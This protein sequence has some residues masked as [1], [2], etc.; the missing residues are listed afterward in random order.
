MSLLIKLN[1]FL[2]FFLII[3]LSFAFF[4]RAKTAVGGGE[5][6]KNHVQ[7]QVLDEQGMS[8]AFLTHT[9]RLMRF[10][11]QGQ[12][13]NTNTHHYTGSWTRASLYLSLIQL[14]FF[15]NRCRV[16]NLHSVLLNLKGINQE[17]TFKALDLDFHDLSSFGQKPK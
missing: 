14:T 12:V 10:L 6:K 4:D 1:L 13:P 2:T 5:E 15:L 11:V 7:T 9:D 3:I 8:S 17:L 16:S